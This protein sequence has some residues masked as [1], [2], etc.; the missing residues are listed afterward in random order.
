MDV[1]RVHKLTQIDRWFLT[2]I[3]GMVDFEKKLTGYHIESISKELLLDAK[4]MN[5]SDQYIAALL[6]CTEKEVRR[7]RRELHLLPSYKSVDTCAGEFDATTP[8]YYSTWQGTDEVD[9]SEKES[10]HSRLRSH[11]DWPRD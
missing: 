8:Y 9:V 2:K 5:F 11:S 7:K 6:N 10:A 1:E 4:K 3:K